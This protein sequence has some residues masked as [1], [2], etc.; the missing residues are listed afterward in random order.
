MGL[1]Y[2][3]HK[4]LYVPLTNR[5]RGL[6]CNLRIELFSHWSTMIRS[7]QY[8]PRKWVYKDIYYISTVCVTGLSY[9]PYN[10]AR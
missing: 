3:M 7:Y 1:M 10:P 8:V 9:D 2:T 5:V 4:E 6:Y